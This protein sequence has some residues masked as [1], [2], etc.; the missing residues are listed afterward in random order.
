M[1][2]SAQVVVIGGGVVGAS[3]LY[4]LTR[5]GWTDVVLLERNELTAGSTWHSAGGMHTLN[6]DPNVAKLQQ[7]T[8][9]L[10]REIEELSGRDCGIHIT[11][12]CLLADTPERLD[13]LRMAHARGRY[14]GMETELISLDEAKAKMP[15]MDTSYFVGAMWDAHEGHVDPTGVTNA[16]ATVARNNGAEVYRKSWARSI[17]PVTDAAAGVE[18]RWDVHVHDPTSGEAKGVIRCEHVVNAGGLWAREVGRM[19][20]IELPLLAM[21]HMY[22]ITEPIP[23]LADFNAEV[24]EMSHAIDFAGEIYMRQEGAGLLLGTYEH[25]CVPWSPGSTP[26][27][28]GMR[29]LSPDL[30]RI[31]DS[32]DTG[33]KH[34]PIF[35]EVGIKQVINGPFTFA[36]DGNPLLGPVRGLPGF[37]SAC[38]VMAGL[39]QGGGVG[40]ALANWM[41]EGDPGFDVWGM[42]IAR[43]GDFATKSWTH[44]KV[45]ENYSRRFRIQFPNEFLPEG[46]PLQTSPIHDRLCAA[47][48]VWGDGFGLESALWFQ[49]DGLDPVEEVTFGR[50]N[51]WD[52]VR[53]E[54]LAVRSG[55]G[56]ME[57][58]GFSKFEFSGPGARVFLDQL[59]TNT[60]PRPG[61]MALAPLVN[62]HGKLIGDLTI[63][64][65]PGAAGEPLGPA[66][67]ITAGSTGNTDHSERFVVFGSGVAERYY[68]RWFDQTMASSGQ[69][70][71]TVS[72]RTLGYD[73]CGLSIAGPKAREVLASV[74]D[75]DVSN[76]AFRFM[77]FRS[78]NVGWAPVWCGR[79]SFTGDL[80]YELW[81]P[82]SYQRYV[83]DL[84]LAAGAEHGLRLFG[85]HA[86][87]S[88]RLDK[89]FGGWAREYRPIYDPYEAG[90][91]P[92]V[93][94]EKSFVGRDALAEALEAGPER[95]LLTWTVDTEPGRA[96]AD[97]IGDE[98]IWYDGDVVGWVTSGG[99]SHFNDVSVALGYVPAEFEAATGRFEIEVV[100]DRR[101]AQLVDGCLWDPEAARLR[102]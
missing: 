8:I 41:T 53:A 80:G 24:G 54:T 95:R 61:R 2:T 99:Y 36:P 37:W 73:L 88:L 58:T 75:D 20:G 90:L 30:D 10:Y 4:H 56:L 32:L 17:T 5:N 62:H 57:T 14:L 76:E 67:T 38:A 85:L 28:F 63:A 93:K 18:G 11:G 31:A 98:P 74:T 81:M 35:A 46:R 96:G 9:E 83:F 15:F 1:K 6:G 21:E 26:W 94:L 51:A 72:Y 16:Y 27:D 19:V 92:F 64:C 89:S 101:E 66:S 33:F 102:S 45:R 3:V 48:A 78:M 43:Y 100:G 12:G 40:L 42:D 25:N 39:S 60:V 7:Y 44:T 13:W 47:N 87:N 71:A 49:A 34:F 70:D 50:S 77:A 69:A 82:S 23:E 29:L 65:L 59:S 86:L 55:V 52:Q 91:G 79:V 97:V 84:L 68:E 22:L